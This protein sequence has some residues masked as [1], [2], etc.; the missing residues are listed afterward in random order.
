MWGRDR[1]P[2][3]IEFPE[4]DTSLKY[5]HNSRYKALSVTNYRGKLTLL[6]NRERGHGRN[7]MCGG[8][9]LAEGDR[10]S[11]RRTSPQQSNLST[12]NRKIALHIT[13][14]RKVMNESADAGEWSHQF[15]STGDSNKRCAG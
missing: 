3:I 14:A 1:E 13:A 2:N 9:L 4:R 15:A 12:P 11:G 8:I 10:A 6:V 5:L 7:P